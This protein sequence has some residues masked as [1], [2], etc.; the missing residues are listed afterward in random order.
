MVDM[1]CILDGTGE[2]GEEGSGTA[3]VT[4]TESLCAGVEPA[5]G[6]VPKLEVTNKKLHSIKARR[7][8][9]SGIT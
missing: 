3:S 2:R 5:L 6:R 8:T 4:I 1:R 9:S 7:Q